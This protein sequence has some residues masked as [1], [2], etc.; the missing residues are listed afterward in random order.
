VTREAGVAAAHRD[1]RDGKGSGYDLG[2][3]FVRKIEDPG[4]D[5]QK[6]EFAMT[7]GTREATILAIVSGSAIASLAHED[8][9]V[10]TDDELVAWAVERLYRRAGGI[11]RSDDR[12]ATLLTMSPITLSTLDL[13]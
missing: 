8:P 11:A 9:P 1:V 10:T 6:L 3:G 2:F 7:D 4:L 5:G 13:H 12:F